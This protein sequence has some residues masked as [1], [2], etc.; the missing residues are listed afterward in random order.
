MIG[1]S[2]DATNF[3][4]KLLLTDR[5]VSKLRETL[6]SN[7]SANLKLSKLNCIK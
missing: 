3:S 6:A 4:L 1:D 5:Q 7:S 2:N